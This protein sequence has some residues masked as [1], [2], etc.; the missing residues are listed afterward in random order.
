M[1]RYG[2]VHAKMHCVHWI[3]VLWG[4]KFLRYGLRSHLMTYNTCP[5]K[6]LGLWP[7]YT[8]F[9]RNAPCI[10]DILICWYVLLSSYGFRYI[11][12]CRKVILLG[13]SVHVNTALYGSIYSI[14]R[15]RF[16]IHWHTKYRDKVLESDSLHT[17]C[18]TGISSHSHVNNNLPST[19]IQQSS[20]H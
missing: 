2:Q 16:I 20:L 6:Y 4:F 8:K 19:I 1:A 18:E 11:V 5:S 15:S 13:G 3:V 12:R 7:H 17:H 9:K 14:A 10:V